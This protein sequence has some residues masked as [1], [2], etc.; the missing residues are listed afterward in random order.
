[1]MTQIKTRF[2]QLGVIVCLILAATFFTT[3]LADEFPTKPIQL[4]NP[5]SAGGSHDAHARA[6]SGVAHEYFGVPVLAVIKAGGAGTIGTAYV[7][8]SKP[9]GYT[10]AFV[11]QQAI[12]AKPM[13]ENLPY[14]YQSFVAIGRI[15]YSPEIICVRADSPWKD[16]RE[17]VNWSKAN[18]DKLVTG[19]IPGLG[20]DECTFMPIFLKE[21]IK[22]K[23]VPFQGGGPAFQAFLA[24]DIDLSGFFP[25]VVGEYIK[26][27]KVRALAV[28][29]EERLSSWPDIP[30]I[31]EQGYD[32]SYAMFRAVFAP[33]GVPPERLEKLRTAF[34]ETVMDKSFQSMVRRMG[35]DIQFMSGEDF[36]K[37]MPQEAERIAYLAQQIYGK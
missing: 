8:Q 5:F 27:G 36:E 2:F 19:G 12:I 23:Y 7:A 15:N 17:L 11:D 6:F 35:E 4:I 32:H 37:F 29:S 20:A 33:K 25:S 28:G 22:V 16:L 10:L 21:N 24:G 13:L 1:M 26:A 3:A 31:K 9:D 30:T 34:K 14:N 18:P